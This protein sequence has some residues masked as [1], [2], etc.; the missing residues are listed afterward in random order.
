[1]G[2]VA[3]CD[4]AVAGPSST[5][6][7]TEVRLGLAAM[8][9]V[10]LA[11][12]ELARPHPGAADGRSSTP[13]RTVHQPAHRGRRRVPRRSTSWWPPSV[14]ARLRDWREQGLWRACSPN[15]TSV[16]TTWQASPQGCSGTGEVAEEMTAFLERRPPSWAV[17]AGSVERDPGRDQRQVSIS[18]RVRNAHQPAII[19]EPKQDAW[20]IVGDIDTRW[21]GRSVKLAASGCATPTS[22]C[23]PETWCSSIRSWAGTRRRVVTKVGE[24]VIGIERRP[25]GLAFIPPVAPAARVR[26]SAEPLRQRGRT[27][28]R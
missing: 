24:G 19:R 17:G 8:I 7:L 1:M 16:G 9:S 25:R 12:G 14:P 11:A 28:L 2:L 18:T 26:R 10:P 3:A 22:T 4:L 20:E 6:A 15:S 5:F 21:P 13:P 23:S 27:A